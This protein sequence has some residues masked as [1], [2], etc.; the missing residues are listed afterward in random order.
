MV[1]SR[2]LRRLPAHQRAAVSRG[3][4]R[5]GG[6]G[7]KAEAV[8]IAGMQA[9]EERS[10]K[11]S[12][13]SAPNREET[14][15]PTETSSSGVSAGRSRARMGSRPARLRPRTDITPLVTTGR[16]RVGPEGVTPAGRARSSRPVH[17][18]LCPGRLPR[19]LSTRPSPRQ[20]PGRG[21]P[22]VHGLCPDIDPARPDAHGVDLATQSARLLDESDVLTSQ[23]KRA[24]RRPGRSSH[25]HDDDVMGTVWLRHLFTWVGSK[26]YG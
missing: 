18:Q 12:V 3:V 13:T 5:G 4:H 7:A 22:E 1:R 15:S 6:T 23:R 20:V 14:N 11:R 24:V 17:S 21:C 8:H 9:A 2:R 16:N 19:T 26:Y 25:P 10:M